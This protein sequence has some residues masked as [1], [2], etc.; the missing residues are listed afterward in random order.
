V[1]GATGDIGATGNTTAGVAGTTGAT[2]GAGV[3]GV[4]GSTGDTGAVGA[5]QCWVSYRVFWF[6]AGKSDIRDSD[7]NMVAEIATYQKKNP[8]LQVGID[9][10]MNSH[11]MDL[12]NSRNNAIHDAL[13]K[14]GVPADKI[15]VGE[16]GDAKGRQDRRVEVLI[17]TAN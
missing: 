10:Y 11:N 5:V 8:S 14:A 16:F 3:Q 2:G 1:Q 6:D 13:V 4:T 17:Q 12:S 9:G 15:K 7:A